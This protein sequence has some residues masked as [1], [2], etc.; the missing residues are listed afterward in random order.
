MTNDIIN[1]FSEK[2]PDSYDY[3]A[4]TPE[5]AAGRLMMVGW[6]GQDSGEI[7]DLIDEFRPGGLIFFRRNYP[8]RLKYYQDKYPL[9]QDLFAPELFGEVIVKV[10]KYCLR[11]VGRSLIVAVDQEGGKVFRLPTPFFQ[12]PSAREMGMLEIEETR[13]LAE[14]VGQELKESGF[15]LNLA[16]VLDLDSLKDG[17]I[18]SRSF[19]VEPEKVIKYASAFMT[20]LLN[21]GILSCGKH[22]PGLGGAVVDPH[23]GVPE[24]EWDIDQLSVGLN[25][26]RRMIELGLP[27]IMTTHAFYPVLDQDQ[28]ATFSKPIV[29]LLRKELG[30]EGLL[31][32]DDLE[33]GAIVSYQDPGLAAVQAIM[34][35]HDLIL[36]CR[37][38]EVIRSAYKAI[39]AAIN[40]NQ[41]TRERL[42]ESALRYKRFMELTRNQP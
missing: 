41:I 32:T 30:F 9:S 10:K 11:M 36:V 21:A 27:A 6:A 24:I 31:L 3:L 35:G 23:V 37:D 12:L 14:R 13:R 22:F 7:R 38:I 40:N 39:L 29:G 4:E 20:G 34:A 42:V 26:F 33:M 28:L 25:I 17:Y 2:L 15:N 19:G 8:N 16:P 1:R 5:E 18:G